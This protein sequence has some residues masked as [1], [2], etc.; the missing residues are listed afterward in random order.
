MLIYLLLFFGFLFLPGWCLVRILAPRLTGYLSSFSVS[1]AV[2]TGN[3]VLFVYFR[4]PLSVFTPVLVA[5]VLLLIVWLGLVVDLP[6]E[7]RRI[8]TRIKEQKVV[9]A[10]ATLTAASLL[11][12][13]GWTGIYTEVPADVWRHLG[14]I[15]WAY[16]SFE[17][18]RSLL[19]V[20]LWYYIPAW[21]QYL[22]GG[23]VFTF[24]SGFGTVNT[25]VQGLGIYIF[26]HRIA[27][28]LVSG[29]GRAAAVACLSVLFAA[30]SIGVNV[31]S[32][33]RYYT[34][35][36]MQQNMLIYFFCV[37]LVLEIFERRT[38]RLDTVSML[39]V[40][41]ATLWV[42]HI[43]EAAFLYA[44]LL[45]LSLVTIVRF[46]PRWRRIP[47]AGPNLY[48]AA[49]VTLGTVVLFLFTHFTFPIRGA[50]QPWIVSLTEFMP[51]GIHLYIADPTY[52]V[53]QSITIWGIFVYIV[54][55][56][57][58]NTFSRDLYVLSGMLIPLITV[59]NPVFVD[60]FLRHNEAAPIYRFVY[61]VPLH[62]VAACCLV[63]WF[64]SRGG[65]SVAGTF[66]APISACLLVG[67]LLP[68]G[69]PLLHNPNSRLATLETV[70]PGNDYRQ[71]QDMLEF[72]V[73]ADRTRIITDPVTAYMV[74]GLTSHK[75]PG[76]KFYQVHVPL[77]R[78]MAY[79]ANFA[80]ALLVMN[81]R[82]G[83][84]S[85]NGDRAGH[86]PEDVLALSEHYP[87]SLDRLVTNHPDR[88]ELIWNHDRI[89]IYR[90]KETS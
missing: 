50:V 16:E 23:D 2:L 59:F 19:P 13:I 78:S 35:G 53:Y 81:N 18:T 88:F 85:A 4:I 47:A 40:L 26:T 66:A 38:F 77:N 44:L 63:K 43:Q 54:F 10:G 12:Y 15:R 90:I 60:M 75:A 42:V 22:A 32:Y 68:T 72:L 30:F 48:I 25:L 41:T 11:F 31:F 56:L 65:A 46:V 5:E 33:L 45:S 57:H 9:L 3:V 61:A 37:W 49:A 29:E 17:G 71:W 84:A 39:G 62:I 83:A 64:T 76:Y 24:I 27:Q 86:W 58:W 69:L 67:L 87:A 70:P 73:N 51:V 89:R 14:Y 36:P 7:S 79:Y 55:L 21:F 80:G 28:R 1:V 8:I 52:Q 34:F 82:N 20:N 74:R 6:G